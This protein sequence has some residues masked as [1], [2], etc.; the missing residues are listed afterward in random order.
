[1]ERRGM[2]W[3][4]AV[5]TGVVAAVVVGLLVVVVAGGDDP[6]DGAQEA[7]DALAVAV[8]SGDF[9]SVPLPV[10]TPAADV[11]GS[12]EAI[13]AGLGAGPLR[14]T[15]V[16][17]TPVVADEDETT[18]TFELDYRWSLADGVEWSY[19]APAAITRADGVWTASWTPST[20]HP[21]I[22]PGQ[23]LQAERVPAP[24]GNV[25][26]A[27]G[28][29][30]FSEQEV[31]RVGIEPRATGGTPELGATDEQKAAISDQVAAA[32]G[33]DPDT[34][35]QRV[36]TAP[37]DQL[38]EAIRLRRPD[39]EAVRAA[40]FDLPG[41]RFPV[42]TMLLAPTPDF[43][44]GVVGSVGP[45]TAEEIEQSDGRIQPGDLVGKGGV[46]AAYDERLAGSPG[47]RVSVVPLPGGDEASAEEA[48]EDPA[49][50]P[51]GET[52]TTAPA[53]EPVEVFSSPPA[54]GA[55]VTVTLDEYVQLAADAAVDGAPRPTSLVA[56]RPSTGEVLAASNG[57]EGSA[58]LN[59]AFLGQFPPGSTFKVV[60]TT[61][62]LGAGLS[63]DEIVPCP[64]Q[65][66]VGGREFVNA[67]GG[68]L[69]DVAFRVD[70]AQSC[71]TAFVSLADRITQAQLADAAGA[72]G[73]AAEYPLGVPNRGGE[74]PEASDVV[75]Q[76]ASMIGQGR[77]VTSPLGMA[78]VAASLGQGAT[79]TPSFV[80]E[81]AVAS[82]SVPL[83]PLDPTVAATVKA[84]MGDVVTG[85]TATVL[86]DVPGEAVHAKTGTAE[87]GTEVPPRTHAWVIA[88]Q[89][90]LAV[91]VV[92]ED[93]GFGAQAA[94]PIVRDFLT[95]LS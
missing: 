29:P 36:L 34:L 14:P 17:T 72:L 18:A 56:I 24:R 57:G 84:L 13:T 11:A 71:N 59:Q 35:R 66:N 44:R 82:G 94:G 39:F 15:A 83:P 38:V 49:A 27:G 90:D 87:F 12:Y 92:V 74:V 88:V 31:V 75:E 47:I 26:G 69:G 54:S 89:G 46:Q 32:V 2:I 42:T 41:T 76:A 53:G 37:D 16:T 4:V 33:V 19:V 85:G 61:A 65:L 20:V 6:M 77:V 78:V 55:D 25:L 5:A 81:P 43:A 10:E 91:A 51:A 8:R 70:F 68:A 63:P 45:A 79:V 80:V 50:S 28:T 73:L 64:P 52:G 62:L 3:L 60:S 30:L 21:D 23:G 7:A 95:A 9:T 93:G 1:M 58:G 86:A 22:G 40:I 67:E 48:A